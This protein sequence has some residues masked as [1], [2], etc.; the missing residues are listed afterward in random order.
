MF[1]NQHCATFHEDMP[2]NSTTFGL[3]VENYSPPQA[4]TRCAENTHEQRPSTKFKTALARGTHAKDIAD[5]RQRKV[6][7][8]ASW[9]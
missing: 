5:P 6:S 3:L 4:Q 9:F 1:Q 8:E 2:L 7:A